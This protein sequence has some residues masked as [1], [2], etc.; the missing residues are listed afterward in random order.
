[1]AIGFVVMVQIHAFSPASIARKPELSLN[2]NAPAIGRL[3]SD[4]E[5]TIPSLQDLNWYTESPELKGRIVYEDTPSEYTLMTA[6][7]DWPTMESL[8]QS[9][10][11]TKIKRSGPLNPIRKAARWVIN[12]PR[13]M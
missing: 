10:A 6:G 3:L 5:F 12:L 7:S 1:M 9:E 11:P 13:N 4:Q 2:M 8:S